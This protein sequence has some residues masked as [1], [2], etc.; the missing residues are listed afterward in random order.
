MD[1]IDDD[2][3]IGGLSGESDDSFDDRTWDL[4]KHGGDLSES[5]DESGGD[6]DGLQNVRQD[7]VRQDA[8]QL[9]PVADAVADPD[10]MAHNASDTDTS[11]ADDA[12]EVGSNDDHD[13]LGD[14]LVSMDNNSYPTEHGSNQEVHVTIMPIAE[15][16]DA[17]TD[18]DSEA[19]DGGDAR[20]LPRRILAAQ[21][22][23][24]VVRKRRKKSSAVVSTRRKSVRLAEE[25]QNEEDDEEEGPSVD[26]DDME[27]PSVGMLQAIDDVPLEEGEEEQVGPSVWSKNDPGNIGKNI[28][29]FPPQALIISQ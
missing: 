12:V 2:E 7:E 10:P 28:P 22:E 3:D 23:V 1:Q 25:V 26:E 6:D 29:P 19:S 4:K 8:Q 21:G 9:T 15:R 20:H 5:E 16:G 11:I 27:G 13:E 17:Q 14:S 18:E 24:S